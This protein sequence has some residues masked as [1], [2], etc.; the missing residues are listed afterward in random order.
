MARA[1]TTQTEET[2]ESDR[3]GFL[4]TEQDLSFDAG[5]GDIY[6]VCITTN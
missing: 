3:F 6:F 4:I 2:Y 1:T 5:A